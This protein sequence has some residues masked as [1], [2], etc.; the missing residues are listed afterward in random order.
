MKKPSMKHSLITLNAKERE[1][2]KTQKEEISKKSKQ[3]T[4]K[5]KKRMDKNSLEKKENGK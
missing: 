4:R 5:T 1:K 3:R 2:H